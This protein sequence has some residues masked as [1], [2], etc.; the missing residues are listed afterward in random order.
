MVKLYVM[1]GI[2]GSGKSFI[3]EKL[4]KKYDAIIFSSDKYR[5]KVCGDENCQDKNQEV[6]SLLYKELRQ[7][8]IEGKNCIF[9]ATNVTRKD[10]ARIFNQINGISNVEVTAYVMRTPFEVC[11][12]NDLNRERTVGYEVI[13]K[14]LYKYEFPQRFEGFSDIIIDGFPILNEQYE[15]EIATPHFFEIIDKMKEWDQEN[16]HHIH[17]L[18]DHCF[19]LAEHFPEA[20]SKWFAGIL[21]DVGKMF[22]RFYD[23]QG[24]AHYYNHDYVGT[25]FILSELIDFFSGD[26]Q[27]FIE[28][29]L[30]LVNYHM[31]GH[32]DFRGD[33]EQKYRKLFGDDW[34]NDLILFA[35]ADVKASGTESIHNNLKQW[36]KIDKLT[37]EEIRNKPEYIQLKNKIL[38]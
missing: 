20:T 4:A 38:K 16:P 6:F 12:E 32:K 37:L 1:I 22:T 5:L 7:A 29:L 34:Y 9:D 18:Y 30:F 31:R 2:P 25:Y 13:K 28:H 10:R 33:N 17:C 21:H 26:S 8:L 19:L 27:D 14:F 23:E 35:D 11:I 15:N 24:I 36:V 3:S